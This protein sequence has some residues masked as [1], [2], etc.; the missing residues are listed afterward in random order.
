MV[1]PATTSNYQHLRTF[2]NTWQRISTPA[3]KYQRLGA[4]INTPQIIST[5]IN[6]YQLISTETNKYQH[7]PT[8]INTNQKISTLSNKYQHLISTLLIYQ[9]ASLRFSPNFINTF[10]NINTISPIGEMK[11]GFLQQRGALN[12]RTNVDCASCTAFMCH[13][14]HH[15]IYE[16][17]TR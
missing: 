8:N 2:I 1:F 16:K 11:G 5:L 6:T 14:A 15:D 3:N 9:K 12:H 13:R 17:L 10:A 7:K 4:N